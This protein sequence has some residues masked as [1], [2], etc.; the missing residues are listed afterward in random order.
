[1][2]PQINYR[3]LVAE[4]WG[5]DAPEWVNVLAG[6]C[7]ASSQSAVARRLEVS[8]TMVNQTLRRKYPGDLSRIE[9]LVRGVY[10]AAEVACPAM[11][12]ISANICRVWRDRSRTFV[13]VNRE[14]V[15]MYRA[16]NK[17]PRNQKGEPE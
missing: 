9:D 17:C 13:S 5:A 3:A 2:K 10:M 12:T 15:L 1:M 11:G 7:E 6:E 8:L 16:C 4:F 14:R